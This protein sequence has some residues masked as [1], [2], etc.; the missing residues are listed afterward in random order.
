M[1]WGPGA[2]VGLVGGSGSG[3]TTKALALRRVV[4]PPGR[5]VSG[6]A[7]LD[8]THFLAL[9]RVAR[10]RLRPK[11]VTAISQGA[12]SACNPMPS[13]MSRTGPAGG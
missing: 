3:R 6:N 12:M 5:V 9:S 2:R 7:L 11:A 8:G 13:V 1:R 4:H 10:E